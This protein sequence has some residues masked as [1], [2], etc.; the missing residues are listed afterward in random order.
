MMNRIL[1]EDYLFEMASLPKSRT[2]LP[3]DLWIDSV[4]VD[5]NNEHS[6]TPRLKVKVDNN[7][8]PVEI[9]DDPK[10]P[11][12]LTRQ[13]IKEFANFNKVKDYIKAYKNILIYHYYKKIG[14]FDALALL[15][16]YKQAEESNRKLEYMFA[17]KENSYIEYLWND[18]ECLYEAYIV[19]EDGNHL[20][21]VFSMDYNG[22]LEE[23]KKLKDIFNIQDVRFIKKVN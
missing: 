17:E 2:G 12:S 4:G 1:K 7:L 21:Q 9:S 8:I 3:Y 10:I 16:T 6:N 19:D 18:D 20:E 23:I 11:D 5:R 22:I 14:D 13:G 15:K